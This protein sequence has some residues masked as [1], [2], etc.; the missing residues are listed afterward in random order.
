VLTK[1]TEVVFYCTALIE[2]SGL[3]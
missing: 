2:L 3:K 1:H